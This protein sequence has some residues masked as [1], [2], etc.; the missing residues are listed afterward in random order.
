MSHCKAVLLIAGLLAFC[1]LK[2]EAATAPVDH[3]VEHT[4]KDIDEIARVVMSE[5]NAE[6]TVGQVAVVAC[7]F[8]RARIF[9]MSIHEVIHTPNQFSSHWTGSVSEE[10]YDAVS[11]YLQ[12]P[13]LFPDDMVYFQQHSFPK[14]GD[15]YLQIG[16][17]YFGTVKHKE[18]K[19]EET[20][21]CFTTYTM[22]ERQAE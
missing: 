22:M 19:K 14:W 4:K 11:M 12:C 1:P 3:I 17:H 7:I 9:D 5:A 16:A 6:P 8:N 2:A 10:C 20:E 21:K 18:E 13:T 15:E